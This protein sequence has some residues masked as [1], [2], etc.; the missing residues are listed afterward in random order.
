MRD[1]VRDDYMGLDIEPGLPGQSFGLG[2]KTISR[3]IR[4]THL[5]G[6]NL[7]PVNGLPTAV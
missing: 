4:S 5:Q 6:S 3:L 1:A 2:D 7:Y